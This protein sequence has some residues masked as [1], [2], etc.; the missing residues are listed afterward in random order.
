MGAKSDLK[1]Q[2][3][4][5]T[6]EMVFARKGFRDVTMKDIVDACGISR[7]GLY[8]Y[9]QDTGRLF[10]DVL[11]ASSERSDLSFEETVPKL[12]SASD[13]LAFFFEEQK[14]ELLSPERSLYAATCE[15][16]FSHPSFAGPRETFGRASGILEQLLRAGARRR[17][18]V[19]P[20]PGRMAAHIM[21]VIEG[22]KI[23]SAS[24]GLT[25]RE[26]DEEFSHILN[27]LALNDHTRRV[28]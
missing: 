11:K 10:L 6:A 14:K 27:E 20:S 28:E 12:E 8:L 7:G 15:Y 21:F 1:K 16:A 2:H 22:L 9:Y 4:I 18:F 25:E 17:E 19:C 26:I 13:I 3:I 23:A 24:F 5:R